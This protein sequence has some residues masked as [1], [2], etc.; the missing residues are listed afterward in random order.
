MQQRYYSA[1]AI[2]LFVA[3]FVLAGKSHAENW[4]MWRGPQQNGISQ[5]KGLPVEWSQSDNVTWRLPLPGAAPSTPVIWEDRIFLTS[6]DRDSE[7]AWLLCVDTGGKLLWQ[8]PIGEGESEQAEKNNLAAPS[9]CTDGKH[10]WTMTGDGT[11]SCFDF[12]G[13]QK[14]Q[15]NV[16]DRYE[17]IEMPWGLASSPVP[18][19]R[20]LYVQL[21]HLNSRRVV[22]VDQASGIEVWSVERE[23]DA[24]G[25][26]LRSYATPAIYREKG[27]EYLLT[28]GQDFI[29]AHNLEDG[30]EIWRCGDFHSQS[31]YNDRMHLSSSPVVAEGVILVPSGGQGNFQALRGDGRGDI[32]GQPQ[33][34]LW[35]DYVSPMRPSAL[36]A[37]SL[38][39]ICSE[40]GVLRCLDAK[41]GKEHYRR[42]VHRHIHYA[43]PVFAEG[44][45]YFTARDGTVTVVQSGTDFHILATNRLEEE[46][47][48]S[49]AVSGRRIY[50]RSF[51]ALYAIEGS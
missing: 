26:C 46:I 7:Q 4:P 47:A 33:L 3:P 34:R 19:G 10:V 48:A 15:F 37:D 30:T 21:F 24:V 11:I 28:H 42:P 50:L 40:K 13:T 12:A 17:M 31:G 2:C 20:L 27:S 35:N 49:P 43:S 6:T 14:W 5:E 41:T 32:T 8:R 45:I 9:P 1:I 29:V 51:D 16:E 38:A 25:K 36:L 23:T 39:Y 18:H 22:A 44:R